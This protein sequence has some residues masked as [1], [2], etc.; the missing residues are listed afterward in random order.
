MNRTESPLVDTYCFYGIGVPTSLYYRF[1]RAP[2]LTRA[3]Y[4]GDG[5]GDGD[6][7]YLDNEFC[8]TWANQLRDN[9]YSF[10]STPFEGVR[11]SIQFIYH[12]AL[13]SCGVKDSLC[14]PTNKV[15][16]MDM[17]S[18]ATVLNAILDVLQSIS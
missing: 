18:N 16:H 14:L 6:Q 5:N 3:N 10:V 17:V 9:G 12:H 13:V 11:D 2:V 1:N 15:S 8:N 4:V 7:D